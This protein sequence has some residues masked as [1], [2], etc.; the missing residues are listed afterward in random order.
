MNVK[1]ILAVTVLST[2]LG[3]CTVTSTEYVSPAPST[4]AYT[5]GYANTSPTYWNSGYY[6]SYGYSR[7]NVWL[8][9]R[10]NWNHVNVYGHGYRNNYHGNY[11][12]GRHWR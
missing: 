2:I 10:N 5:V 3:G 4:Y 1:P 9:S 8:G 7:N 11:R 6:P 12:G